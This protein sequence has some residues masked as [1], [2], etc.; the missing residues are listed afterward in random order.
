[1]ANFNIVLFE[2]ESG[3]RVELAIKDINTFTLMV[4]GEEGILSYRGLN[5]VDFKRG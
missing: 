5:Y 3:K 4:E 1:M 2:L